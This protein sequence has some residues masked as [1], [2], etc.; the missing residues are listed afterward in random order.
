MTDRITD[1]VFTD[2]EYEIDLPTGETLRYKKFIGMKHENQALQHRDELM[3]ICAE[4]G[5]D[6]TSSEQIVKILSSSKGSK[7]LY[8]MTSLIIKKD[9]K[10]CEDNLGAPELFLVITLFFSSIFQRLEKAHKQILKISG[11]S[12][13]MQLPVENGDGASKEPTELPKKKS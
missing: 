11:S 1:K 3:D 13:S 6:L 9:V 8:K 7:L 4:D 10:Y 2:P 12:I 5:Y